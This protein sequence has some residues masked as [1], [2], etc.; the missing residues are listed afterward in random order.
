MVEK[1]FR[2]SL[3]NAQGNNGK[4]NIIFLLVKRKTL[5]SLIPLITKHNPLAVYSV[6]DIRYADLKLEKLEKGEATFSLNILKNI[7]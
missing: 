6:E 7:K 2:V 4:V 5:K 3:V 1:G